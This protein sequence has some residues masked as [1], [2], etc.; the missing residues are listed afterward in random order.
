MATFTSSDNSMWFSVATACDY[1]S[2]GAN[3]RKVANGYVVTPACGGSDSET[4]VFADAA[5]MAT[6]LRKRYTPKP[7]KAKAK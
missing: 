2:G 5:E 6:W 7:A 1:F 3:I 4:H